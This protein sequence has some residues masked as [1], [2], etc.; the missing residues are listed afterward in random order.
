MTKSQELFKRAV[1]RIPG[2]VNSPV[3]A[4]GA[5]GETPRFIQGAVGSSIFD[6]GQFDG[7]GRTGG[8]SHLFCHSLSGCRID[9]LYECFN[10]NI[11]VKFRSTISGH[12][13][14]L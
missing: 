14:H 3:R 6:A 12:F 10:V 7:Y 9:G 4:Y 2:G 5:I 8:G 13:Q 1:N 11:T